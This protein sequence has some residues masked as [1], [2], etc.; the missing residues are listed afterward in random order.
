MP[1]DML[2]AL[3][4]CHL[5]CSWRGSV[6]TGLGCLPLAP[7]TCLIVRV[8]RLGLMSF[9]PPRQQV[10]VCGSALDFD[11]DTNMAGRLHTRDGTYWGAATFWLPSDAMAVCALRGNAKVLVD[12]PGFGI[13]SSAVVETFRG[14]GTSTVGLAPGVSQFS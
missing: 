9:F 5:T 1:P 2:L 4:P 12:F 3:A 14:T 6:V 8:P 10:S 11:P 7:A 13:V